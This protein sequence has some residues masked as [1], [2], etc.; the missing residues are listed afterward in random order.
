LDFAKIAEAYGIKSFTI[1]SEAETAAVLKAA[2]EYDGACLVHCQID[3]NEKVLPM[4]PPGDSLDTLI[5]SEPE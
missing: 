1:N 3:K 4:V 2:I 5:M